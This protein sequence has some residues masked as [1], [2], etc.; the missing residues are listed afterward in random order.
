LTID[1]MTELTA[2]LTKEKI[3]TSAGD[4][5]R[6]S[7]DESFHPPSEPEVVV[8]PET[9]G[10][11]TAVLQVANRYDIPVTPYGAGSGLDGQSIPVKR[12]ISM[13][14]ER[15]KRIIS[16]N[17]EDLTVTVQPGI[18]RLEL[19]K[20][21]NRHGLYFPIDP[22][23]DASIG[24]MTATNASGTTAVR[25]G[26]M[27]DQVLNLEVILSDGRIIK[28]GSE[29]KKSSSGY[30]LN[31]LFVGSEGTLGIIS[32]ITLKL[33]GIPEHIIAARCTFPSP[34]A[35]AEAA[36]AVLMSGIPI[37]RMEL[38][39][40]SSIKQVNAY[41]DYQFPEEH[42]LFFEFSGTKG[43]AEEESSLVQELMDESGCG[44]WARA[45]GSKERTELWRARH[46]LAYA[47]RHI[48]GMAVAGS[49]VCVPISKL[50][51]LVVY[52]REHIEESG[53]AGGV[54]GHVG[55]GNF[56]TIIVYNPDVPCEVKQ[57]E[58]I[59]EKLVLKAIEV[60]GTCTGEHGVGLGKMKY[61]E[62]E[63]GGAVEVMKSFKTLLDP[64]NRLNP[65]KIFY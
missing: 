29:A 49:D 64:K 11:I 42:S 33:H 23:A 32:E 65:G 30:H 52:A 13:N 53:L 18:T 28:T 51:D 41:G 8:F 46:E 63:H 56:H 62:R 45:S 58:T 47:Y 16:F 27:R 61:Q 3:S 25:Y 1:W 44:N 21:I 60:G 48:K 10:D 12:G 34:K 40:A 39:D 55:D 2:I 37:V 50:A 5:Y 15:M 22:G 24:G 57:A 54:F 19:N 14:F 17:P 20:E 36:H 6:H 31:S 43:S 35:C 38:V 26:S 7:K 59:N 4:R 9:R